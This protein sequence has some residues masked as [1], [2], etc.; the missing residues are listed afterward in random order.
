MADQV[1]V[2]SI[3]ALDAFRAS[4][5]VFATKARRSL[6][7]V[8][9]ELRR[10]RLWLEHDQ[11]TYWGREIGRR[12]K[13]L[14]Q[15]Q[16]D[17]MSARLSNLHDKIQVQQSL[18]LKAKRALAEADAKLA[19][20]KDWNRAYESCADPLAK[21]LEGLRHVLD[22]EMPKAIAYL[23]GVQRSLDAYT[24][25]SSVSV[26]TPPAA[27]PPEPEPDGPS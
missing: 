5:I 1:K 21:R 19:N 8:R 2:T 4:L 12:T 10:T 23:V 13:A 22:H 24:E 25:S 6:D 18:V 14:N 16:A 27:P 17:L 3:D 9:D 20:V 15:A 11:R 7:D 26:E